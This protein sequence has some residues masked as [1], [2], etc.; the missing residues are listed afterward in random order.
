MVE[1]A[2]VLYCVFLAVAFGWRAWMQYRR[3]GD[4]GFRGLSGRVARFERLAGL[5]LSAALIALL[6]APIATLLGL[7]RC[8]ELPS[9]ISMLGVLLATAGFALVLTAQLQMGT[10]WRVGVDPSERTAL[11]REGVFGVVRNPIFSGISA[12]ALGLSLL[13]PNV[14]SV[15]GLLLGAVGLELQVRWV[16]EPYLLRT[17]GN[18]YAEYAQRVGRFL[19]AVGR[20]SERRSA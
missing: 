1:F 14:L 12:F 2:L 10:S 17:H 5:L 4:H 11:I 8:A 15:L 9:W 6:G 18:A 3:T 7:L 20:L 13:V 19:P 16:E